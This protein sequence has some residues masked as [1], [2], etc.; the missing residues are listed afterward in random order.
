MTLGL[1]VDPKL[2]SIFY[3]LSDPQLKVRQV[4]TTCER[5]GVPDCEA[6]VASPKV[7]EQMEKRDQV[8]HALADL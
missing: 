8:F 4:H 3:F 7:I 5:C 1:L 2:R 6:R